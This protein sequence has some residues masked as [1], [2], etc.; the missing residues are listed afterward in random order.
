MIDLVS[1]PLINEQFQQSDAELMK[2][3]TKD[4][5]F[6]SSKTGA[7]ISDWHSLVL[8]VDNLMCRVCLFLFKLKAAPFMY[9][10]LVKK[11]FFKF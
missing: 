11:V 2:N 6:L 4:A 7:N 5:D 10:N 9:L 1:I 8:L 3:F